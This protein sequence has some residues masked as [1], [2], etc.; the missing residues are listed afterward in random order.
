MLKVSIT[1]F[2]RTSNTIFN[3][4]YITLQYLHLDVRRE[5]ICNIDGIV[6]D[7]SYYEYVLNLKMAFIATA[8]C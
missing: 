3:E 6:I 2:I 7:I 5:L 1:N 4:H 8:R